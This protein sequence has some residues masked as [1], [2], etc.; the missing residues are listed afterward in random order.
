MIDTMTL[1][2]TMTH[3]SKIDSMMLAKLERN[4]KKLLS[5]SSVLI[6]WSSI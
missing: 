1:C 5:K 6:G 3:T 4:T 2:N